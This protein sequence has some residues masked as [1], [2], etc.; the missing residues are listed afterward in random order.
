METNPTTNQTPRSPDGY[1]TASI[2]E[3]QEAH[4]FLDACFSKATP[5]YDLEAILAKPFDM[6]WEILKAADIR[7]EWNYGPYQ[8]DNRSENAYIYVIALLG[9]IHAILDAHQRFSSLRGPE[10]YDV[11]PD[12]PLAE[13]HRRLSNFL[14]NYYKEAPEEII[15]PRGH[16]GMDWLLNISPEKQVRLLQACL[17]RLGSLQPDAFRRETF[18]AV[19]EGIYYR[20]LWL[21]LPYSRDEMLALLEIIL[22]G[23]EVYG[24]VDAF[25]EQVQ[26]HI[27]AEREV[28]PDL[29]ASLEKLRARRALRQDKEALRCQVPLDELLGYRE[30]GLMA[31]CEPWA[32]A[33]LED[34]ETMEAAIQAKWY[35]VLA[36]SQK[37]T[38][39]KPNATWLAGAQKRLKALGEEEFK[40]HIPDWFALTL[41]E[42]SE[43]FEER[44]VSFLRGMAYYC[45]LLDD[46][47]IC[48]A[49]GTLAEAAYT[50]LANGGSRSAQVGKACL[51]SL[52]VMPGQEPI[53][54]LTRLQQ[55]VKARHTRQLIRLTLG[56]KAKS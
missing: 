48:Q 15:F 9:M 24:W 16:S 25:F 40:R 5:G 47:S 17:V 41:Q 10:G 23:N 34:L 39:S 33:A 56:Q 7:I 32:D 11:A 46:A 28:Y 1:P 45:S 20:L 42:P 19:L 4:R 31:P 29:R 6:Q 2:R 35:A 54:Q 3:H 14:M 43:Y 51:Y 55:C 27:A 26:R 30:P 36:H 52:S 50:T 38:G 18:M 22:A 13:S 8:Q 53:V 21:K 12:D 37:G 49:V 44:N